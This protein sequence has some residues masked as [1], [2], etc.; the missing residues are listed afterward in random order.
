MPLREEAV[1]RVAGTNAYERFFKC[2]TDIP[3][4]LGTFLD[5]VL[6]K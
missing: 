5:A 2:S 6:G 1:V 3:P 4:F